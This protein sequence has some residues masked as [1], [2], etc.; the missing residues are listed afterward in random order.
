MKN[1]SIPTTL[2][3]L[4][5][6]PVLRAA[7]PQPTTPPPHTPTHAIT[8]R[9]S[10]AEKRTFERRLTVQGTLEAKHY[11]NV[12]ARVDGN[13]DSIYVDEGDFVEAN[14]TTLFQIDPTRVR[15]ALT[16]AEQN[17]AVAKASLAVA[18]A[19]ATKIR[20]EAKKASLDFTRY[21]RLHN[22]AKVTDNEFETVQVAHEQ[23]LAGIAVADAQV[24][25]AQRQV[26]AAD[27]HVAIARKNLDDATITAPI[28]G[29]IS[30]RTAEPGEFISAG[31]VI[32][33]IEDPS[34]I[35]AAAFLP[36]QYYPQI[37]P[38]KTHFRL[39][40]SGQDAGIQTVTY[41]AP[42][43]NPTLRTFEIKGLVRATNAVPGAMASLVLIF[44]SRQSVG[45]P[46]SAIL[47]RGGA[48]TA[49]VAENGQ[50]KPRALQLG[51]QNDGFTEILSGLALGDAVITQGQTLL[52]DDDPIDLQPQN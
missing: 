43:I 39:L 48:P 35:E 45:I 8:V 13:L 47:W 19:S 27:A 2:F 52:K 18:Q 20:A 7:E 33:R 12:A 40:L 42:I 24:D 5:L 9:V 31:R 15:N 36:A 50:A 49:Y 23:A 41:R 21:Q 29:A 17:L 4:A 14:K 25:L 46:S 10:P 32:L 34:L 3:F 44:E 38:G 30:S 11:A 28:S 1:K 26:K 51:L 6:A 16:I 22:E 37:Q